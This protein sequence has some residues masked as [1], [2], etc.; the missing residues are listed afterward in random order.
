MGDGEIVSAFKTAVEGDSDIIRAVQASAPDIK[1]ASATSS[2]IIVSFGRNGTAQIFTNDVNAAKQI[3][4]DSQF[5]EDVKKLPSFTEKGIQDAK[6]LKNGQDGK[7]KD[8]GDPVKDAEATTSSRVSKFKQYL[9]DILPSGKT[10]LMGVAV[11]SIIAF[12]SAYLDGTDGVSATITE[13]QIVS[14][15]VAGTI[16]N[17]SYQPPSTYFTP[18]VNDD[19]NFNASVPSLANLTG[20]VI[21]IVSSS[22]IQV[23]VSGIQLTTFPNMSSSGGSSSGGSSSGGSS[24]APGTILAGGNLGQF[25]D[26][27]SLVNQTNGLFTN[28]AAVAT[29]ALTTVL[30]DAGSVAVAAINNA[31]NVA[32][33]GVNAI[34]DTIPLVCHWYT[35][36]IIA[37]IIVVLI[38]IFFSSS[39]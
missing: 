21:S 32:G 7:I 11:I 27:T 22:T 29:Q 28:M 33:A 24:S 23:L 3:I 19:I 20:K 17:V 39:N 13:L 2:R 15:S 5:L 35:W 34:C 31:K 10:V 26:H 1:A 8:T 4:G 16:I 12:I 30:N 38:V 9:G 14:S 6:G 25:T 36:V 37:V 18:A